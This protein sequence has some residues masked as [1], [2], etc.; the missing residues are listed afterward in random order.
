[1]PA[2]NKRTPDSQQVPE[3]GWAR[4]H[5]PTIRPK[6]APVFAR[7]KRLALV[8]SAHPD[9]AEFT[10]G[11]LVDRLVAEGT[12]VVFY[13]A[14]AGQRGRDTAT[15]PDAEAF[16]ALRAAEARTGAGLLG[17]EL[18][19]GRFVDGECARRHDDLVEDVCAQVRYWK[20]DLV[21]TADPYTRLY[22]Q[23]PDHRAVGAATLEA[24]FP[25]ASM[26]SYFP[27]QLQQDGYGPWNVPEMLLVFSDRVDLIVE[28]DEANVHAKTAAL[29]AHH[30][31]AG[32][33]GPDT[34]QAQAVLAAAS[35][36]DQV[37]FGE[38]YVHVAF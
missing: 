34:T 16:A 26:T 30:S 21:I 13:I 7:P 17:A 35:T 23:H 25:A 36:H 22:R 29:Q 5:T 24:V 19:L 31:Q 10:C 38:P 27:H 12:R 3:D 33:H 2:P 6:G 8:V 18:V 37:R 20:P 9:D 32:S 1:M 4:Q 11:G 14:T 15:H 28:L